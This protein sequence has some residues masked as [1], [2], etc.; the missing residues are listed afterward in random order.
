M[1]INGQFQ[2][3]KIQII[4]VWGDKARIGDTYRVAEMLKHIVKAIGMTAHNEPVITTYPTPELGATVSMPIAFE[5]IQHLHESYIVFDNWIEFEPAYANIIIN[6]CKFYKTQDAKDVIMSW[7][8]IEQK[9]IFIVAPFIYT[10]RYPGRYTL[11]YAK[12]P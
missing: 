2:E 5:A 4:E 11:T 1:S 8:D 6:S 7:L 12:T 10:G 9:N 3:G